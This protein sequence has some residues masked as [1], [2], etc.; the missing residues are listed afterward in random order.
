MTDLWSCRRT[1]SRQ[2]SRFS[3]AP[4][5]QSFGEKCGYPEKVP[6]FFKECLTENLIAK[7][8]S[9]LTRAISIPPY[10]GAQDHHEGKFSMPTFTL[11]GFQISRD[12]ND[13]V[14][15][16]NAVSLAL[17]TPADQTTFSYIIETPATSED[18]PIVDIDAATASVRVSG[19]G[20]PGGDASLPNDDITSLG[21]ITTNTG[22]HDVLSIE[23]RDEDGSSEELIFLIGGDPLALPTDVPGFE[24]LDGSIQE[25]GL[26]AAS[27][28]LAPGAVIDFSTL[29]DVAVSADPASV[30]A[31]SDDND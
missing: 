31:G 14:V 6:S 17:V 30:I 28:A 3:D 13:D 22:S 1:T 11:S 21:T 27:G 26:G 5:L 29:P 25:D 15:A 10:S 19:A 24:A 8:Q 7:R 23:V 18:L 2:T 4:E 16:I 20:I 9:S 12:T